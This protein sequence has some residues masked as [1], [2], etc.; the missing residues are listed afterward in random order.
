M[1]IVTISKASKLVGK[2]TRTIQRHVANGKIS[3]T[4]TSNGLTGIDT[5]ELIRVY[6][7]IESYD[8]DT[9]KSYDVVNK[10]TWS[11]RK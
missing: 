11:C 8:S 2:T 9:K 4:T 3:K 10:K 7:Q 6:G 1:A 5:S